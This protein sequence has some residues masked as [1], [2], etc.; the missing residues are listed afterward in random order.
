MRR[1]L[2]GRAVIFRTPTRWE[3]PAITGDPSV[4]ARCP[5]PMTDGLHGL[6]ERLS[7]SR[8]RLIQRNPAH[9]CVL[10]VIPDPSP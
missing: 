6:A 8:S 7:P 3:V 1:Q 5:P 4:S 9:S 2:F 10:Q